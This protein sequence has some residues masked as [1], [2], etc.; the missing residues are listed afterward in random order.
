[1]CVTRHAGGVG[2]GTVCGVRLCESCVSRTTSEHA[3]AK[4]RKGKR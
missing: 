2:G 4:P 3:C 1:M